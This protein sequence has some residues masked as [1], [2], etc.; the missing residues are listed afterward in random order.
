M[1]IH[2]NPC[3]RFYNLQQCKVCERFVPFELI[4]SMLVNS[5]LKNVCG[6]CAL[7]V[8]KKT[9]FE[10]DTLADLLFRKTHYFFNPPVIP[11]EL[12]EEEKL[13]EEKRIEKKEKRRKAKELKKQKEAKLKELE[14][15]ESSKDLDLMDSDEEIKRKIMEW[16][17]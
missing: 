10:P 16:S 6:T 14:S 2:K 1:L 7:H 9:S 13:E 12:T 5:V 4:S 11:V 8:R 3:P 17:S 15:S